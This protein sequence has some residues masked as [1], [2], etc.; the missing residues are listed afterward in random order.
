MESLSDNDEEIGDDVDINAPEMPFDV[1]NGDAFDVFA[2]V[3][4]WKD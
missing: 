3:Q 2:F 4:S 1:G